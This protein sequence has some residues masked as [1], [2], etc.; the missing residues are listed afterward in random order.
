MPSMNVF[1]KQTK[2]YQKS[3]LCS[4]Y[5]NTITLEMLS[6]FGW[7]KYGKHNIGID[8]F[9]KSAEASEVIKSYKFDTDSIYEKIKKIV[10]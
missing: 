8:T 5:Q 3:I 4:K 10:K 9:G 1:D 2:K 7:A 6:T